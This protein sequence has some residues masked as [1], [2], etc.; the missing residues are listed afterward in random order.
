[1]YHHF[2]PAGSSGSRPRL[3]PN[4]MTETAYLRAQVQTLS[5]RVSHLEAEN[6]HLRS[7]IGVAPPPPP[8]P[9]A[10]HVYHAPPSDNALQLPTVIENLAV[11]QD[12][13]RR[14]DTL[15]QWWVHT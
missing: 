13:F 2:P 11:L 9:P 10:G 8:P 14:Q 7:L 5:S 6:L 3:L 15:K 4:T 12:H 1:M